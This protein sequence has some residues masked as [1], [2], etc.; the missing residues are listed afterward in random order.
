MK[1][2]YI[3]TTEY[4]SAVKKNEA[5]KFTGKWVELNIPLLYRTLTPRN[6]Q[7]KPYD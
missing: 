2:W 6:P 5:M 3:R 1:I 7:S 4:Y